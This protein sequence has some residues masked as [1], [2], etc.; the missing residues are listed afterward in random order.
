SFSNVPFFLNGSPQSAGKMA[1]D[2]SNNLTIT[3]NSNT[4]SGPYS[5]AINAQSGSFGR[6]STPG[7]IINGVSY[8]FIQ[9]NFTPNNPTG[10]GTGK[11]HITGTP[12]GQHK[13]APQASDD[14]E[15][16]I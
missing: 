12:P 6:T 8:D 10:H 9:G 3:D 4:N 5:L 11:L 16:G 7:A 2:T 15:S 13:P 14:W 1:L